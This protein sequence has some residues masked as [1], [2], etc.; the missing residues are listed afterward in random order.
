MLCHL[1]DL[2][3]NVYVAKGGENLSLLAAKYG[4]STLPMPP[5]TENRLKN[6]ASA[7]SRLTVSLESQ[8]H[9]LCDFD[10]KLLF[11]NH[12]GNGVL[13]DGLFADGTYGL[14][15][16]VRADSPIREIGDYQN[17]LYHQR[18][19]LSDED[20]TGILS[21][22]YEV[23][24]LNEARG[25]LERNRLAG[26][27]HE[28]FCESLHLYTETRSLEINRLLPCGKTQIVTN[29]LT[30]YEFLTQCLNL[31]KS[32]KASHTVWDYYFLTYFPEAYPYFQK[33]LSKQNPAVFNLQK[34]RESFKKLMTFTAITAKGKDSEHPEPYLSIPD[35]VKKFAEQY[36]E[37]K[38]DSQ[39]S[40]YQ[41]LDAVSQ[42]LRD[43]KAKSDLNLRLLVRYVTL[44][45]LLND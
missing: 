30:D 20:L 44:H 3:L 2:P 12:L 33:I 19:S 6:F 39:T 41:K 36:F 15:D 16:D 40:A 37:K 10:E 32:L 22:A 7:Q 8:Y 25:I 35:E 11:A 42:T 34:L 26:H 4:K 17:R 31:D 24:F 9:Q 18:T 1:K 28:D 45:K 23:W 43:K 21:K 14:Q 5:D 27:S 13:G 38:V 29:P